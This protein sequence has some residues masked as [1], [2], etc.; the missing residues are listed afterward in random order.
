MTERYEILIPAYM[1]ENSI[2]TAVSSAVNQSIPPT[3]IRV[4]VDGSPDGDQTTDRAMVAGATDVTA[5]NANLGVGAARQALLERSVEAWILFL[6]SDDVL[7]PHAAETCF[8][9][10]SRHPYAVVVAFGW[11]QLGQPAPDVQ[12]SKEPPR[13]RKHSQRNIWRRNPITSSAALIDRRTLL[14]AGG[15]D[16]QARCLIDYEAWLRISSLGVGPIIVGAMPIVQRNVGAGTITANVGLAMER[17]VRL[18]VEHAPSWTPK[19]LVRVRVAE[20]WL[21]GLSRHLDYGGK[22]SKFPSACGLPLSSSMARCLDATR[23]PRGSSVWAALR[24]VK[25]MM[26]LR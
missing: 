12:R 17:E 24:R 23:G 1:S 25:A 7:A 3:A 8:D 18:V 2:S 21:R 19:S 10:V 13:T 14:Q 11:T 16:S 6:D 9:A 4:Y 5:G 20:A 22:A 26:T 15:Y